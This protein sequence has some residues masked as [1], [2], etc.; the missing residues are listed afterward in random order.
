M[1]ELIVQVSKLAKKINKRQNSALIPLI[2][3]MYVQPF[4][5]QVSSAFSQ[6]TGSKLPCREKKRVPGVENVTSF[7]EQFSNLLFFVLFFNLFARA[8]C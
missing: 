5:R 2:Y 1:N 7:T 6:K 4:S 8:L 3:P